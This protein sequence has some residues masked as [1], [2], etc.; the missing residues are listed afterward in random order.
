MIDEVVRLRKL[1][2]DLAEVSSQHS[3]ARGEL[4]V[5]A[6]RMAS[7]REELDES[8]TANREAAMRHDDF[9]QK[10]SYTIQS[11]DHLRY[12]QPGS[13]RIQNLISNREFG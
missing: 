6:T 8:Q 7:M 1:N 4:Q 5:L 12:M 11:G 3:E 10:V 9:Q 2:E 13:Y